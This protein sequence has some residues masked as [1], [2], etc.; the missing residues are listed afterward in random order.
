MLSVVVWK[1]SGI[2]LSRREFLP[3]HVNTQRRN[4]ARHLSIPHRFI[5]VT[6]EPTGLDPEV[7]FFKTPAAALEAGQVQTPEAGR[8]PSCYRRLWNFSAAARALGERLLCVDIDAI[9]VSDL[10]PLLDR[11]EQFV[12]WRPLM[13]WGALDRIGGGLYLLESGSRTEVWERFAGGQHT[14]TARLAG[15]RGSDQAWMSYC[16]GKDV[17]VWPPGSGL[18]SI[19]DLSTDRLQCNGGKALPADARLV[20]F[21]GPVKPWDSALPWVRADWH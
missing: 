5:C 9:A 6:D 19:R 4:F 1:W 16:L 18:Y 12:G 13:K 17:A 3:E 8:F 14:K 15:Y 20:Q 2:N 21:N 11:Q 10:T 7:E